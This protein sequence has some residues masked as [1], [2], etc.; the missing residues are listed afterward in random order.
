[1]KIKL[2][3]VVMSLLILSGND[4]LA[5]KKK[6]DTLSSSET[7][8]HQ[9]LEY[10]HSPKKAT[11]W[12]VFLPGA[13]QIYNR[14]YW[15]APIVWGGIAGAI[16]LGT[17]YRDQYHFWRQE[18]ILESNYP[19]TQSQYHGQASLASLQDIKDTYKQWMETS[20]V[21]A[22]A[23][24]LLQILDANVDAQL[25]TFDVSDDLSMNI[26]PDAYY[27]RHTLRP[28]YG[29]TLTFGFK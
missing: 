15:K 1:M 18:F 24:Y 9:D 26:R 22:G 23:I 5:Q 27:N 8:S 28:T 6:A 21:V 12:S 4:V 13:G 10:V 14:K 29:M 3:F 25:M 17:Y 7:I 16:Y 20:Y 19:T 2:I 11:L